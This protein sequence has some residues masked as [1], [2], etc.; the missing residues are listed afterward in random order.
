MT[1]TQPV[2]RS[3]GFWKPLVFGLPI[4]ILFAWAAIGSFL[5]DAQRPGVNW[6][7]VLF[8]ATRS[9]IMLLMGLV[10]QGLLLQTV[11]VGEARVRA[12]SPLMGRYAL[13]YAS[14]TRV[15]Y[16][17]GWVAPQVSLFDARGKV[18]L[19]LMWGSFGNYWE[20]VTALAARVRAARPDLKI[21]QPLQER[22]PPDPLEGATGEPGGEP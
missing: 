22:L 16:Q 13:D 17:R 18:A 21:P 14:V 15:E 8:I 9:V 10:W 11:E 7:G 5:D 12:W 20:V 4:L 1:A 2:V 6:G 3:R 19:S